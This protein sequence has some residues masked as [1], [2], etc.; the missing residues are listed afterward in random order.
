MFYQHL[1]IDIHL[2]TVLLKKDTCVVATVKRIVP[3]NIEKNRI[4]KESP[5]RQN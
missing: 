4:P 1:N 3:Y 5:T 2:N